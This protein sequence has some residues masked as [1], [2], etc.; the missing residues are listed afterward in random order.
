MVAE[1]LL[2]LMRI[3]CTKYTCRIKQIPIVYLNSDQ[4]LKLAVAQFP[5]TT[6]TLFGQPVLERI[7][8]WL[9]EII[10]YLP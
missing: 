10:Q 9:P 2:T 6:K 7:K 1:M 5:E 3:L 8:G 4:C